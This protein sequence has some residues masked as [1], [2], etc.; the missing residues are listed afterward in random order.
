MI[1]ETHTF[2][3]R[4]KGVREE[5]RSVCVWGVGVRGTS[6]RRV[7]KMRVRADRPTVHTYGS[8]LS[9]HNLFRPS[10]VFFFWFQNKPTVYPTD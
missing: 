9:C 5:E 4:K 3:G 1:V 6:G 2:L 10:F 8:V 7:E